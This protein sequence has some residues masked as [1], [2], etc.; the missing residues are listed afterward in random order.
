MFPTARALIL[1]LLFAPILSVYAIGID[2]KVEPSASPT[3][4]NA[5]PAPPTLSTDQDAEKSTLNLALPD[6][7]KNGTDA[8]ISLTN[9]EPALIENSHVSKVGSEHL[10]PN[11]N[12]T[13]AAPYLN[14]DDSKFTFTLEGLA[15]SEE[16]VM[17]DRSVLVAAGAVA[18]VASSAALYCRHRW[19]RNGRRMRFGVLWNGYRKPVCIRCDG[20]LHV[21][22]D[23][24][25]QCPTCRVELGAYGDNGRT[26]S[27]QEALERIRRK[28]YW[29]PS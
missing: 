17:P 11:K 9:N 24:S 12:K 16:F 6:P 7:E 23:Y 26:I 20:P 25:F 1:S 19:R 15:I 4:E 10:V 3:N 28:Q 14:P 27:P 2:P 18:A 22:N 8:T 21:L 5:T 13:A 29:S